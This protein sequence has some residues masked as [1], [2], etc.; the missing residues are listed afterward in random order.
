[1]SDSASDAIPSPTTFEVILDERI[2]PIPAER[3]SINSIRCYLE[4]L[5]ME[6]QRILIT[7]AV[8]GEPANSARADGEKFSVTRISAETV[9]L[10]DLPVHLLETSL[11]QTAGAR[12]Q[13]EQAVSLVLINDRHL[14]R[15]L[16]WNLTRKLKEPLL[17]LSLVPETIFRPNEAGGA[18]PLQL[19]RWQLQQLAVIIKEVDAACWVAD[20]LALS[21]ALET[22][23]LPW[24]ESLEE[25][26]SLWHCTVLAGVRAGRPLT[27]ASAAHQSD[28]PQGR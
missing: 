14:A 7:F 10:K 6:Q 3:R 16:W 22:R 27:L 1:M 20:P 11:Q 18:S 8:D 19:R 5:A 26:I 13:V 28:R 24:L 15:E 9:D 23:V 17:T 12:A 2:I 4:I 21:N 25:L